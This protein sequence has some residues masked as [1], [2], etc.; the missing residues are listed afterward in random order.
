MEKGKRKKKE[1]G[2]TEK[3]DNPKNLTLNEQTQINQTLKNH[4]ATAEKNKTR[5]YIV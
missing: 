1:G 5:L 3:M 2:H 4:K